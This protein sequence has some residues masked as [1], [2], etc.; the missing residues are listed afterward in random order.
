M[1]FMNEMKIDKESLKD[2]ELNLVNLAMA[3]KLVFD[4]LEAAE[5]A[6]LVLAVGNT[7]C[8]K[9]TMLSSL[10]YGP[11]HLM[12]ITKEVEIEVT[13]KGVKTTKI[14]KRKVIDQTP[15]LQ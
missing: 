11:G 1:D 3:L 9:S 12:E 14:V 6:D 13:K 7:G 10:I 5:N 15:E 8:G 2:K 4:E